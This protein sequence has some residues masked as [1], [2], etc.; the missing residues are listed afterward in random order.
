MRVFGKLHQADARALTRSRGV[1]NWVHPPYRMVGRVVLHMQQCRA[2]G[3][4]V[5]PWW[6]KAAWWPLLRKGEG[7]ASFVSE[8]KRLGH[9]VAFV[10]GKRVQTILRPRGGFAGALDELPVGELWALQVDFAC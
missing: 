10:S 4:L 1:L 9:S 5:V 3:T 2:R 6:E 8:A 7:W